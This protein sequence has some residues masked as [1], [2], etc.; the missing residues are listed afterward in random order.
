MDIKIEKNTVI[1][2]NGRKSCF[3]ADAFIMEIDWLQKFD[4]PLLFYATTTVVAAVIM[5]LF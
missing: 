1:F 4:F 2:C 3:F 5:L